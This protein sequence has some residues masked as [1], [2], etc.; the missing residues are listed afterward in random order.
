MA[1]L[2]SFAAECPHCGADRPQ[3]S[4]DGQELTALLEAGADIEAYCQSCDATWSI[5]TEERADLV[6][7][8]QASRR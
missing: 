1:D 3:P 4:A 8:L 2:L 6:R 7:T 5:S